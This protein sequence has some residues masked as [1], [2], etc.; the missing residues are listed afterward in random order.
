VLRGFLWDNG[1][2]LGFV[3]VVA[4][5]SLEGGF[6]GASDTEIDELFASTRF[7][8]LMLVVGTGCTVFGGYVAGSRAGVAAL[9][10]GVAVGV[11]DLALAL[12]SS[13]LP[14]SGPAS[15]LWL[16]ALGYVLVIP[17]AALGGFLARGP[18]G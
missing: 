15:P 1:L 12:G 13:L 5:Y 6:S 8:L 2:T 14:D 7:G 18:T 17:A 9:K 3:L 4:S 10:N 16:D 11:A